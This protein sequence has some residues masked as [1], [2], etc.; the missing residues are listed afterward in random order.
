MS[1]MSPTV[2]PVSDRKID[3]L[4]RALGAHLKND[5]VPAFDARIE[6]E[7]SLPLLK[8][9]REQKLFTRGNADTRQRVAVIVERRLATLLEPEDAAE[10]GRYL[11]LGLEICAARE[12]LA[13]D[14]AVLGK[15]LPRLSLKQFVRIWEHILDHGIRVAARSLPAADASLGAAEN[16]RRD[17]ELHGYAND[18]MFASMRVLNDVSVTASDHDLS[19]HDAMEKGKATFS[20]LVQLAGYLNSLDYALDLASFGECAVNSHDDTGNAFWLDLRDVRRRLIRQLAIRRLQVHIRTGL[21]N[22][23]FVREHLK[24][25]LPAMLDRALDHYLTL[26]GLDWPSPE[27]ERD[28]RRRAEYHLREIDAGDDLLFMATGDELLPSALYTA[29]L[30]LRMFSLVGSFVAAKLP[31]KAR[32]A[33][34]T[35]IPLDV[36]RDGV[37]SIAGWNAFTAAW[38]ELTTEL[39][40]RGYF[41]LMRR[42]FIRVSAGHAV[43]IHSAAFG[44]WALAIRELLNQGG[45]A[46]RRYGSVWEE[47]LARGFDDTDWSI[48]GR[49]VVLTENGRQVTEVD[50]LLKREDLLLVV[51][52]KALTGSGITLYDH[53]KNRSTIEK[54]CHQA[55]RAAEFLKRH[56]KTLAS[57]TSKKTAAEVRYIQPLV[58]TSEGT[59]DGWEYA[60]VPVAGETIR[61]A[62]TEGTKV[63]YFRS[64]TLEVEHTDYHL[65]REDLT[66]DTILKALRDPIELKLAPE[67]GRTEYVT[68]AAAGIT[69]H[70]AELVPEDAE[71]AE[72]DAWT[73][74]RGSGPIAGHATPG[75]KQSSDFGGPRPW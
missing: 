49:N 14:V 9:M 72:L 53:W 59:F 66:T 12:R 28:L 60:G 62:I 17:H 7:L 56:P 65:R 61:K 41:E 58:M 37:T 32:R 21:R 35:G 24:T 68:V 22:E 48:A 38:F 67:K 13:R 69:L 2:S 36:L 43:P 5:D 33:F 30:A 50:L 11:K 54:G 64:D 3:K 45:Q 52:V 44:N 75:R 51:E 29:S 15:K 18:L 47:W 40:T 4:V 16:A 19:R 55:A 23:R 31:G 10:F 71:K 26:A 42:P 70:I 27:D 6:A 34:D 57:I 8:A 1:E 20:G 39:P 25:L 74:R 73:S 63:E 46:G